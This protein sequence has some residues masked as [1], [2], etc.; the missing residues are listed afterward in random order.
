MRHFRNLLLV[1]FLLSGL[2]V[3][4]QD[5]SNKGKEF[6]IPYSYHVGAGGAGLVMTLYITSDVATT[7]QVA[8]HGGVTIQSGSLTAGQVV[9]C[10]VPNT[11]FIPNEGLYSG[12]AIVVTSDKGVVVYSYITQSAVSGATVCLPTN[13]LGRE[14]YSMNFTQVSNAANSNS[15]FTIIAAED[16]TSV[17]ITPT[18]NT[19]N[20]W[21]AGT[22]YTINLNKG[23]IYQVLGTHNNTPTGGLYTGVDLTG[24]K[25]KS[26]TSGQNP[27]KRIA[28]FSGAGKIRIGTNCGTNNSSDNLYQQLYPQ[29]TWGK[30]YLTVPSFSR[31]NNFYRVIRS[32]SSTNVYVN[33]TL[34]PS[35]SFINGYY[36]FSN[37]TPNYITSD[38]PISVAQYFTTQGCSSNATPYDPDMIVLNPIEQNISKVTLVSSNLVATANRQHH[39]H[40]IMRSGGT[41]I[42]S[43]RFDGA[44]IP[45]TASWVPHPALTGYSYLYLSNVTA[46]YH[47]LSSDSGFNALAYGYAAAE[48][49]GYSAG[50]N[51]KDLYQYIS[52]QNQFATV[53]FPATCRNTPFFLSMT[54]PYQP[55]QIQW[56]FGSALNGQGISDIT[57][58]NPTPTG[59]VV[60]NGRTL[61]IYKLP[62]PYTISTAG[63]YQ[64]KVLATN[65]SPDGCTGLQ[66][67]NFD[68]D[69]QPTPI[70]NFTLSNVCDGNPVQFT[71]ASST[72]S[73]PIS[74]Y[75][76]D[77][78]DNTTGS[79]LNPSHLYPGP[80]TYN[81]RYSIITDIGCIS[82]TITKSVTVFPKPTATLVGTVGLCQ[83]APEP[84]ITFTGANGTPP[85]TFTY[86]LNGG[87]AQQIVTTT[88]N[89]VSINV[90]TATVGIYTYSLTN[91]KDA[92]SL[93]CEQAQTGSAVVTVFAKPTGATITGS[94]AVC[95]NGTAPT[96]TL[97][98]QG[99]S[100]NYLFTYNLNGGPDQTLSSTGGAAT[101]TVPTNAVGTFTYNLTS[102]EDPSNVL[103]RTNINT[104]ATVTVNP[105]PTASITGTLSVCQNATQP[106]ITFTGAGG[107]APYTFV[108]T[109]NGGSSQQVISGA[110]GIAT[111]SVPTATPGTFTY[112]LQSVTDAT[113]SLCTQLQSGNAIVTVNP[114][115]TA[116]ISGATVVCQNATAPTVTF[117][118]ADGTAPYTFA[119]SIN[120]GATQ[121]V[122]TTTGNS[123]TVSVPTT[124]PGSFAYNLISVTDASSTTCLQ[125]Q[126]GTAIITVNPLPTASIAGTTNVCLNATSPFITFTGAVGT[127]PYTFAFNINGGTTQTVTTTTGNSVTV[128][129][130]TATAGTFTYNLI[131][132][133]DASSTVCTQNQSGSATVVV[134]P[135]PTATFSS[136]TPRCETG[137]ISFTDQS[138]ANAGNVTGWSWNFG[139]PISGANNT[140]TLQNPQHVFATAGTYSVTLTVTTNNGCVS[141]NPA[142]PVVIHSK[143]LAGF[144]NPEV[145]LIDTYAQFTDTS[146]VASPSAVNNWNWDFGDPTSGANNTSSLQNPQHSYL[147][148]GSYPVVLIVTSNQG[149]KDTVNQTLIVNGSFP[150]SNFSINNTNNLCAND[151]ISI[152]NLSTVL[153]GV[154]TKVEIF[155]D[156]VAQPTVVEIDQNPTPGKVYK[157]KYPNFQ[158]PLSKTYNIRYRSYSGG[159]CSNDK[160]L[161]ITINAAPKVQFNPIPNICLDAPPYQ[162]TQAS[163]IGGVP[164]SLLF[165][166]PGISSTGLFNPS[167]AGAGTHTIRYYFTSTAGGCIDSATQTIKVWIPPVADFTVSS[168]VCERQSV[169]FTNTSTSTEGTLTQWRWDFGDGTPVLVR[170]NGNP[171]QH[172]YATFGTFVVKLNVVTSN[173]C[174]SVA[175][176]VNLDVKP[177]ARP[178]FSFPAVSCLP[179]ANIQFTNLSSIPDGTQSSFTYLWNFGDPVSGPV[180]TST[181][182]NP[183]HI[184]TALGPYSVNLQVTTGAGCIRDTML[185]LN[186]LHPQPIASFTTDKIDVCIGGAIQF[187]STSNGADGT[188]TQWFWDLDNGTTRNQPNF[189]YTYSAI[190][191]Y[192]VSHYIVNSFNCRSTTA[193]T[194]V[195]VNPYPVA[196]AG[197]DKLMLEGGQ[198]QLTPV[199]NNT[200]PITIRWRPSSYLSDPTILSPIARPIDDIYYTLYLITDKGCAAQDVVFVKVLKTPIVPNIFSPNGDGVHD[201]W[202]IPYL[203][204][205]PGCTVE[206]VNRYGQLVFRSVGYPTPWDGRINGNP[207]PV[208]TYYF[209]IDPK[210]GRKRVAGYV[211]IIR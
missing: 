16:N 143:P 49:Y 161:P 94:T 50:A 42:S 112:S 75:Y 67:I 198:T 58:P 36:E 182:M 56:I 3:G 203:D 197:P 99:G 106:N 37:G 175:K 132:V 196:D 14:Y 129:V 147:A 171:V 146:S 163:E 73:R 27:C 144:I 204:S 168:P 5:F 142:I 160:V 92:S 125:N 77:F 151:S 153:P 91:V 76:W 66:E 134:Y 180:N 107:T 202:V 20:G 22:T 102:V 172:T 44:V 82:D 200:M 181:A 210:N 191:N 32:T 208:G 184:Y 33:G 162:I 52:I 133:T 18:A 55:T 120:G 10:I 195:S 53:N 4:A 190:G 71:D 15:Y 131:S 185:V 187:N 150:V 211:D 48:S 118:G 74:T 1:T 166:G 87:P 100:G 174:V 12:K 39:M 64:I 137:I 193:T 127:A 113:A 194:S 31:P 43:F 152:T 177:L 183:A 24:S 159:V 109:L 30:S 145:C 165:T 148:L 46:G 26:V 117:T 60:V 156:D 62:N 72:N 154:I 89:S 201:T 96:L 8:I 130:P 41:G 6:W 138:V 178:N 104:S 128:S 170:P 105:L 59:T 116:S 93:A 115:P 124:T 70:A 206:V 84:Q 149:C 123:V 158:S 45:S 21:V 189:S 88:G 167:T 98:G 207:A 23:Q 121:T 199:N 13:V 205:Y 95:L 122:T 9:T 38:E 108:Y 111:V 57:L 51:V 65:P 176:T 81:P 69:V 11:Y 90:P 85:Y 35:G 68:L 61:Y 19:K 78:G 169:T 179:N 47:T 7:Y 2:G 86:T 97:T 192:N 135:L 114:L 155:W 103:C 54:F 79:T 126:T 110:N 29:A 34:V 119:Y 25:I 209:V 40:V 101:I 17:E 140:S 28:V 141:V 186:T 83:G 164:G 173:G 139:D 63:T 188:I 80:A 157:H 136:L